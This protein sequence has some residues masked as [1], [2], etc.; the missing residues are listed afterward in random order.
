[1]EDLIIPDQ[2]FA[3]PP[4]GSWI[5]FLRSYGPTPNNLN[6]FDEYVTGA[7]NR[8][9]VK[10]ITL[11]SPHLEAMQQRA[12]SGA[13]GSILIAGTAETERPTTVAASGCRSVE[14]RRLGGAGFGQNAG[15]GRW[16]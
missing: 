9:K 16:P 1:M 10:P 5:R 14:P 7:L 8:A 6:L 15:F 3:G 2:E 13:L 11:T 4:A 12:A